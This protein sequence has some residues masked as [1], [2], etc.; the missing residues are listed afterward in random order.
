MKPKRPRRTWPERTRKV[1]KLCG[2]ERGSAREGGG[3]GWRGGGLQEEEEDGA[4]EVGVVHQMLV[5]AAKGVEDCECLGGL[6]KKAIGQKVG[7]GVVP[8]P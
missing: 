1:P 4:G 2:G 7:K 8:L 6:V 5:D 3:E